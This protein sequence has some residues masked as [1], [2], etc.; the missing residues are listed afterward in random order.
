MTQVHCVDELKAKQQL[1]KSPKELQEYVSALERSCESWK[2]VC[3]DA[4]KK[5]KELSNPPLIDKSEG[6]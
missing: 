2:S 6:K 4:I 3:D 5:I 1:K